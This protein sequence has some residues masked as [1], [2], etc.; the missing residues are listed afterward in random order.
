M[1]EKEREREGERG[2][3]REGEREG[4]ERERERGDNLSVYPHLIHSHGVRQ[5]LI[6]RGLAQFLRKDA[7]L[8]VLP[9]LFSSSP[10]VGLVGG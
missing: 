8:V 7:L 1:N 9:I 5:W 4:G 6:Y 10:L 3:E 2:R